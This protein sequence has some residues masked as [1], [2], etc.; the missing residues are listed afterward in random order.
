MTPRPAPLPATF[1]L[2]LAV[3]LPAAAPA[4]ARA[5]ATACQ[6]LD[7]LPVAISEPGRYCLASDFVQDFGYEAPIRILADDVVLDCNG[8]R[9]K[10][11][12]AANTVTGIEAPNE[13]EHVTV[14]DCVLDG[15]YVGIFL[16][17][18]TDPGANGNRIEGNT[19]LRSRVAGIYAIGSNNLIERNRIAQNTADYGGVAYGIYVYSM[20]YDG[21]GNTIRDNIVSDFKPDPP[22][23]QLTITAIGVS[24]LRNTEVSGNIISGLYSIGPDGVFGIVGY[25]ANGTSVSDNIILTPPVPGPA[26]YD[27]GHWYGIYLPGTAEEMASNVCRGNVV[28]HFNGNIYGC[29]I[30]ES[31]GL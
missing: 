6:V 25:N 23:D 13:R 27:G 8:H 29:T 14:R 9:L 15:W 10:H 26:P 22:G 30:A 19:V 7:T 5:E 31:L 3:L 18:S 12:S 2:A 24:N 20:G 21:V 11:S 28:G 16:S 1:A 4:P 17:A